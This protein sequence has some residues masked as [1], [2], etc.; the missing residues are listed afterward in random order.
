MISISQVAD[1]ASIVALLVSAFNALQITIVKRRIILNV[2][3]PDLL[4]RLAENSRSMNLYLIAFSATNDS[5]DEVTGL[6]EANVRALKRRL[7]FG[8]GRICAGMLLSIR[9][10]R[11]NRSASSA[12]DLY[13]DLQQLIQ[14]IANRLE[15]QRILGA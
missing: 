12:R 6:C 15:E 11:R 5:F 8:Q 9:R 2:T 1:W 13:N 7:G 10:Y 4:A 14:E 3:L